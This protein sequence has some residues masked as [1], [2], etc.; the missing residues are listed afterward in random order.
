MI[1]LLPI[2]TV[3]TLARRL[4]VIGARILFV[5]IGL[6]VLY[7]LEPFC[8]IRIRNLMQDRIGH[9][10][11]N[12]DI[13]QRLWQIKGKPLRTF[14]VYI[15]ADPSNRQLVDMWKRK[16]MVLEGRWI[17]RFYYACLPVLQ[18]T[19]Y[20]NPPLPAC[21]VH[22]L[23]ALG[24]PT[25]EF[26]ET[27][28]E[29]GRHALAAMGIGPDDW[30]VC[31]HARDSSYL[32]D[33]YGP[34]TRGVKDDYR[35]CSIENYLPAA[36]YI[37]EKGGFAIRMG[38]IVDGPLSGNEPRVIDYATH[39]RSDFMDIYLL[40]KC[41]FFL[42]NSSGLVCLP[43]IFDV[44]SGQANKLPMNQSGLGNKQIYIP[45]LLRWSATGKILP[46]TEA[47]RMG[48]F[49]FTATGPDPLV[50]AK[51]YIDLGLEWVENHPADVLDLCKDM[52]DF[53]EGRTAP[54]EARRL[55]EVFRTFF[56]GPRASVY[57]SRIGPRFALKYRYLIEEPPQ[58]VPHC[59]E[60]AETLGK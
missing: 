14:Y 3:R 57:S 50:S 15:V 55:Q 27:E 12:N 48:L 19:R 11:I 49:A 25:L 1:A 24:R 21:D 51:T 36:R 37:A 34:G 2:K 6:P 45:K 44:P 40:A 10:A 52:I 17:A 9:L 7:L 35:N 47:R 18:K 58:S 39:H 46:F 41:R 54:S 26:T 13:E 43:V 32:R 60:S 4:F 16:L 53:V 23:I 38:S 28:N 29:R 42:G 20:F 56:E 8:R 30:F 59:A 31:F 22:D 5:C 33:R